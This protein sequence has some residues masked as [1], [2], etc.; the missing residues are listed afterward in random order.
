MDYTKRLTF[1]VSGYNQIAIIFPYL[2]A[3]PRYLAGEI[4]L[5][6]LTQTSGAF[7]QVEAPCPGSSTITMHSRAGGR[8]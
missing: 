1:Y 6:V 8:R 2:V 5:S 4:S 7:A 3:A